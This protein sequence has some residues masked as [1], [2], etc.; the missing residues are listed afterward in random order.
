MSKYWPAI[1]RSWEKNNWNWTLKLSWKK[2]VSERQS[3][4]K[5]F[6]GGSKMHATQVNFQDNIKIWRSYL[7][8]HQTFLVWIT[9]KWEKSDTRKFAQLHDKSCFLHDSLGLNLIYTKKLREKNPIFWVRIQFFLLKNHTN[10]HVKTHY[11]SLKIHMI[12][13][14]FQQYL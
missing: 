8:T 1:V 12:S 9:Q 11:N 5:S 6:A 7:T 13:H 4:K 2:N 3:V 14:V 10:S